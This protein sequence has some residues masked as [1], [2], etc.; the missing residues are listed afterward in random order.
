MSIVANI[1]EKVK[2][3]ENQLLRTQRISNWDCYS[4]LIVFIYLKLAFVIY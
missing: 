4:G 3:P 2:Q 1:I